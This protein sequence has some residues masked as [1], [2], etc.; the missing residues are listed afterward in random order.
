MRPAR[1]LLALA[2][3]WSGGALGHAG[4]VASTPADGASLAAPPMSVELRFTEPVTPV[5]IRLFAG[6]APAV[7][8]SAPQTTSDVVQLALPP[9]LGEG[10]YVVSFR[11]ISIDSHPVGGSIVFAVEVVPGTPAGF[12]ILNSLEIRSGGGRA[13]AAARTP[14]NISSPV[15]GQI[16]C[17]LVNLT[18]SILDC[19][20]TRATGYDP[21]CCL[22][23]FLGF[24]C[25][26]ICLVDC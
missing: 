10:L 5:A 4:L 12:E 3:A 1:W 17:D 19:R 23:A 16:D 25:P 20:I 14:R 11:V 15:D 8:L 26:D 6:S 9:K 22:S 18:P 13:A 7:S 24:P 2:A 21:L